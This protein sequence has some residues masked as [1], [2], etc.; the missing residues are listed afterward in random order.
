MV[1]VVDWVL[2]TAEDAIAEEGAALELLRALDKFSPDAF[3]D[4]VLL[5]EDS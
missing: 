3:P 5:T 1:E 2:L 4:L